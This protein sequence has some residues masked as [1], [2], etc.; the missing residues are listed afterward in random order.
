MADV[1]DMDDLPEHT[2]VTAITDSELL[3]VR[4]DDFRAVTEGDAELDKA[5]SNSIV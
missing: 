3:S 5:L 1:F 4:K 2:A